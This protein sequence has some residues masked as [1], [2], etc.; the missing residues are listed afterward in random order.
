LAGWC[1]S[2]VRFPLPFW[3]VIGVEIAGQADAG[4]ERNAGLGSSPGVRSVGGRGDGGTVFL[5][6]VE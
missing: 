1:R 6:V 4:E 2:L 3:L 5:A